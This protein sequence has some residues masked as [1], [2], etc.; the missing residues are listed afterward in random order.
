MPVCREWEGW[1]CK[2]QKIFRAEKLFYCNGGYMTL[3]ICSNPYYVWTGK[4]DVNQGLQLIIMCQYWLINCNKCTTLIQDVPN[5]ETGVGAELRE[6]M[7]ILCT[8]QSLLCE[9]KTFL[10]KIKSS[11][12]NKNCH[13][14]DKREADRGVVRETAGG[15]FTAST[16]VTRSKPRPLPRSTVHPAALGALGRGRERSQQVPPCVLPGEWVGWWA[17]SS[18]SQG[19]PLRA[20][21]TP[22]GTPCQGLH[23]R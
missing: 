8:L 2:A 18:D 5:G 23:L 20:A 6:C 19:R 11:T 17:I 21:S 3:Y 1:T 4:P 12:T 15:S 22:D 14:G 10:K 13:S 9:T 16:G 7:W